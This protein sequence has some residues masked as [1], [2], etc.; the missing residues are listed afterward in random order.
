MKKSIFL[1]LCLAVFG[2]MMAQTQEELNA[3]NDVNVYEINKLYPRVNVMPEGDNMLFLNGQWKFFWTPSPADA[4][5]DFYKTDYDVSSWDRIMVPANWELNGYGVPI[6]VNT[7]NEFRPN[8]PPFAPTVD[9]PVGCYVTDFEIPGAWKDKQIYINFGAVKSAYYLWVNGQFVGYTE[10]AKT[11]SDFDITKY[12]H[13]GMNKLA[14][15]CYRFSNGSYFECQDFW[16]F[17]GIERDVVIY[18][19]PALNIYEYEVHAGL[20]NTYENGTFSVDVTLQNRSNKVGRKDFLLVSLAN[21]DSYLDMVKPLKDVKFELAEDGYYYAKL[22]IAPEDSERIGK[23]KKWSAEAPNLYQLELSIYDAKGATETLKSNVGFRTVEI[24]DGKLLV[25]GQYVLIKGV[26]RHEH[27]PYTGHAITRELMEQDIA[28]MKRMNINTVRTCHYPDDPYWYELCDRYGLYVWDEANVES[29]AQGYGER[30]L[31]KHEEYKGMIWS[32]NRNMLERDKNHPSVIMW[33]LGNECGNGVNFEYTYEWMKQRDPSRP[34]TYE[35]SCLDYNTDVI[36]L[37]YS[38]TNYLKRFVEEG[39]DS[40]NRPFIMVEYCHAMGNSMGGLEDYWN[41]I[42]QHEQLQGGCIW[43]WVDQSIIV[44]DTV[45]NVQ[46]LAVG[47]DL[48]EAYGVGDDDSFCANGVIQSDRTPHHHAAEVK[49]V[50]QQIKFKPIDLRT[51]VFEAKNWFSFTDASKFDCQYVIFSAERIIHKGKVTLNMKPF[52]TQQFSIPQPN[53]YGAPGEEFFVRFSVTLKEDQ[54]FMPAGSE[55]AYDEFQLDWPAEPRHALENT[56]KLQKTSIDNGA[57][58]RIYNDDFSITFDKQTG[59]ISS[60]NYHGQELLES[61][62]KQNFWRAPT[63]ND[64]VD[65]WALPRWKKA[66]LQHLYPVAKEFKVQ[67]QQDG[68]MLCMV[69]VNLRD[70]QGKLQ[71]VAH[72]LYTIYGDGNVVLNNHIEPLSTVTS[73]PKIGMQFQIGKEYKNV[74]YFGKNTENYPDRNASGKMGVHGVNAYDMFEQ[75]PEPQDN[76]NRTDV[77]W[78]TILNENSNVG[79]FATMDKPFNFSMYNFDDENLSTAER[80]NELDPTDS[81]TVNLDYKQAPIGTATC[82]PGVEERYVLKNQVYEYSLRFKGF[83]TEGEDPI[84]M[85]GQ[86]AF[87]NATGI[88]PTPSIST[89]IQRVFNQKA[90][91][92]LHCDDPDAKL[93]YTL[94]GTEPTEKSKLYRKPFTIDN[95]C[96]LK[97]KAFKKNAWP[98]FTTYR[99]FERMHIENTT[100]KEMPNK[101]Y[102]K[103]ADI[104]LMD[105]KLGTPSDYANDWLGFYGDD[106]EATIELSEPMRFGTV[107][108]G[109]CHEPN[110]WVM[111]PKAV[112][113]S[114]SSDGEHF[115]E[116]QKAELPAYNLPDPMTSMGRVEARAKVK[117]EK[118]RF[119]RV[120]AENQGTLPT[121]H[122]Y[123]GE[124]AWIMVDE[125]KL[126]P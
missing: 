43:D 35:R 20:D 31:A 67:E 76:G 84:A 17:S 109:F 39:L 92:T 15:K 58:V 63:L 120:R 48:G 7:D 80:I 18:A 34:V 86:D 124:K 95:T 115:T 88:V 55:I 114:F 54:A 70:E 106:M 27:D 74:L 36:G 121:W 123:A 112:A 69:N 64:D 87:G 37:M 11:N 118:V 22:R 107:K 104:A 83:D 24:K 81:F 62:M 40:L 100:F 26:N 12:C 91:V 71:I 65:G 99:K 32:R 44:Y 33:S 59:E 56:A 126:E 79:F 60:Y 73:F 116:W 21:G 13:T 77:R 90:T 10:D 103:N 105:G 38:S 19:K 3:W 41:L 9:N 68:T 111:W 52:A 50:Y 125:V 25:N 72:Q 14:V 82:G 46:W 85:F 78:L 89:D 16:R 117:A 98:S 96:E 2:G 6:Y 42:E 97:V 51:G 108:I 8:T 101:N 1:A 119:I 23:V 30:S 29:H 5:A 49:K 47:G 122:P 45:K 94:D 28:L 110:E 53:L 61:V 66:G 75:H 102:C 113:V 4:P 93:Y 57:A